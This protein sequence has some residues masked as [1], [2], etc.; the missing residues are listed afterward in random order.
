MS[1]ASMPLEILHFALMLFGC[2]TRGKGAEVAALA[3]LLVLLARVKAIL[4]RFELADHD[5]PPFR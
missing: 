5:C 1:R 3:C 2:R 4:T